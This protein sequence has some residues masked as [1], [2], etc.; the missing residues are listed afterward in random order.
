M[1]Q[2]EV[3]LS[4][5]NQLL[6]IETNKSKFALQFIQKLIKIIS[7][8]THSQSFIHLKANNFLNNDN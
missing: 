3:E 2:M 8:P 5:L 4:C 7:Q 1:E 6:E